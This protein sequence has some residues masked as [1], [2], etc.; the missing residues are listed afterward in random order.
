M[1]LPAAKGLFHQAII[2]SGGGDTV[3]KLDRATDF[4]KLFVDRLGGR[5]K[6]LFES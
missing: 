3:Y 1:A 6:R 4:A 5:G 2:G